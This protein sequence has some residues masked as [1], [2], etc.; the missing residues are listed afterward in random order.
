MANAAGEIR[1]LLG[2]EERTLSGVSPTLTVLQY[3]RRH[4]RLTGTKEGCAEGDCGACTLMLAEPDGKGGLRRWSVNGCIQFVP[5][6]HG[7]Q[8]TTVEHLA[9]ADGRLN[10]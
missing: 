1:F 10:P 4:E 7:R 3:L 8:L 6:L 5:S 2:N 9:G